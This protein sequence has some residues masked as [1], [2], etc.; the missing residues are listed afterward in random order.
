[1]LIAIPTAN[2]KLAMHFGHVREFSFITVEDEKIAGKEIA[3]PPPH[4]PGILPQW[5]KSK[6][7]DVVIAGGM[8]GRAQAYFNEYGIKVICGAPSDTPENIVK[9]FVTNK[10]ELGPNACS[11]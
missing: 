7:T 11:H 9:L 6:N 3:I 2:G 4:E 8:G 1:M 10:L 5:L